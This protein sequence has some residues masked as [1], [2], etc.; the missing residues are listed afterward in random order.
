MPAW[1]Q[2][3]VTAMAGLPDDPGF[4]LTEITPRPIPLINFIPMRQSA[5]RVCLEC[6]EK[7]AG[8]TDKRF[9]SDACRNLYHYHANN[10]S[11]NYVRNVVNT[12]KRNRR[13][14]SELNKGAEGKTKVH[15]DRL[16]EKGYNFLYHT[17]I[18]RTRAGNTYTFCFEQGY[19]EI[20]EN[21]Y[22]LVRRDEYLGRAGDQKAEENRP[23]QNS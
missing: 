9:C 2:V 1:A 3:Q 19:L 16:I 6:G 4:A 7:I 13:I 14:L 8:R 20:A 21:L 10:S 12:L 23:G 18:Y 17:H 11:I 22:M 15:R 5:S